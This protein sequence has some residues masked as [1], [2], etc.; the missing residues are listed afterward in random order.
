MKELSEK[1]RLDLNDSPELHTMNG[2]H[3][4][5]IP[6]FISVKCNPL[7]IKKITV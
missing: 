4:M 1:W 3:L 6:T 7:K 5:M 2:N